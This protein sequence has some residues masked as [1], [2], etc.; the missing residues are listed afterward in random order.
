MVVVLIRSQK[1]SDENW[2]YDISCNASSHSS[3]CLLSQE[4]LH[5]EK[6][7]KE[8]LLF[9]IIQMH[10]QNIATMKSQDFELKHAR[11]KIDKEWKNYEIKNVDS[12]Y[13]KYK[14]LKYLRKSLNMAVWNNN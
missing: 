12:I 1:I 10:I 3:E 8:S 11:P 5:R 4:F 14:T 13:N 9:I 7:D 2:L 6:G